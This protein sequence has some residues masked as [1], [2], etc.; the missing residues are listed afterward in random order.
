MAGLQRPQRLR[1]PREVRLELAELS[2]R[3]RQHP[4]RRVHRRR[5]GERQRRPRPAVVR[6]FLWGRR[7]L[8]VYLV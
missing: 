1:E 6:R 5:Q 8:S 3:R 7:V 2:G 4:T